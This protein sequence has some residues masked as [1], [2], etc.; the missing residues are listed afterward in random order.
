MSIL[1]IAQQLNPLEYS[2]LKPP[3]TMEAFWLSRGCHGVRR[4]PKL[5]HVEGPHWKSLRLCEENE[6]EGWRERE[7]K[8]CKQSKWKLMTEARDWE[9]ERG[10]STTARPRKLLFQT[11][12]F[13]LLTNYMWCPVPELSSPSPPESL[14]LDNCDIIKWVLFFHAIRFCDDLYRQPEQLFISYLKSFTYVFIYLLFFWHERISSGRSD[15]RVLFKSP[16][17][18]RSFTQQRGEEK[19]ALFIRTQMVGFSSDRKPRTYPEILLALHIMPLNPG[20]LLGGDM[21]LHG[22]AKYKARVPELRGN[23]WW[24]PQLSNRWGPSSATLPQAL[25]QG[26][27]ED[28]NGR[29]ALH[30]SSNPFPVWQAPRRRYIK[31]HRKCKTSVLEPGNTLSPVPLLVWSWHGAGPLEKWIKETSPVENM[32]FHFHSSSLF[33]KHRILQ[34][35]CQ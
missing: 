31:Q 22:S 24:R 5:A 25:S 8:I 16:P 20:L 4:R 27:S 19:I 32:G 1:E 21:V 23:G 33:C 13:Q 10:S 2:L 26:A 6:M 34:I 9:R 35:S 12:L 30:F 29:W 14:T 17:L 18:A 11:L 15:F 3:F 7:R 28:S